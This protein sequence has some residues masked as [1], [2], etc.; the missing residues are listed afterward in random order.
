MEKQLKKRGRK[1]L[2]D[3]IKRQRATM[4]YSPK[5][6][7]HIKMMAKRLKKSESKTIEFLVLGE[8]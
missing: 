2:P 8:S 3:A 4:S 5:F 7:K 1:A 6:L